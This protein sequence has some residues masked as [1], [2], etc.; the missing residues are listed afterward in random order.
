MSDALLHP[1]RFTHHHRVLRAVLLDEEGWFVLSD[2]VRLLGRYLG[3]RAPAA[4]CD[5]AP[6]P[7]ATAEQRE[8][9]FA[10]CHALE[11]HLDTDQWRLA[12]LHDER[13]GPRQDCLVSESGLYALLWLAVPGA[14]RGLR[15]WV[16]GSVLPRLRSQAPPTPRPSAPCCTGKPPRSTPCTGKA[17]PG[18]PSPTAPNSSTAHAR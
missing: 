14:A 3:G 15:R 16:S 4:L 12:W 8:R 2:L 11:R 13:H 9:L 6:W 18:S 1:S 17:R 5:E 7:L 10:L